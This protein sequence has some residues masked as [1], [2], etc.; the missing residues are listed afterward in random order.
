MDLE[1]IF[2]KQTQNKALQDTNYYK[3]LAN[4]WQRH[5]NGVEDVIKNLSFL[6]SKG[7]TV[8][9]QNYHE[10]NYT[11]ATKNYYPCVRV[12]GGIIIT[13]FSHYINVKS[14]H[15][16]SLTGEHHTYESFVKQLVNC[17]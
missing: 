1:Q 15:G 3:E 13:K 6:T 10:F 17:F 12:K 9:K 14:L 16:F 2:D 4:N 7:I 5:L 11:K 8:E